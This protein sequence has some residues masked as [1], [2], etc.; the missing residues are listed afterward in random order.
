LNWTPHAYQVEAKKFLLA[1]EGAALFA[2][3]GLGK[4]SITLSAIQELRSRGECSRALVVAPLRVC[5]TVW[6]DEVSK[7][8]DFRDLR[9][10]VVHGGKKHKALREDADIYLINPEGLV[11]LTGQDVAPFDV[12]VVDELTKFKHT[13]TLRFKALRPLLP[14]FRR[15][16]GLTGTPTANGLMDLFGQ[17]FVLDRGE[18]LG[19]YITHYRSRYF[20]QGRDGFSW[21]LRPGAEKAIQTRLAGLATTIRANDHLDMPRLIENR[22]DV[23][24]PAKARKVYKTFERTL[25]ATLEDDT[26]LVGT[27]AASASMKCRQ[28]ASGAVYGADDEGAAD[29]SRV[30]PI[31]DA[32]LEALRGLLDE[33]QGSPAIVMYNFRHELSRLRGMLGE[34]TP[35]I[36]GGSTAKT[37]QE[38]AAA[39]NGGFLPVLLGHPAAMGHGLNLQRGGHHVVWFGLSWDY[40]L[41]DQTIRRLWR[42]GSDSSRVF[43]H[44]IVAR[45]TVDEA[46]MVALQKKKTS[47]NDLMDALRDYAASRKGLVSATKAPESL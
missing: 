42:Q 16:W 43:V 12:L 45:D 14:T 34:D 3:P 9:V 2:E 5:Y 44:H 23:I 20:S 33:L 13:G 22:V 10:S 32:K 18:S 41:Y 38:L 37:S 35:A 40:E 39:W 27:T 11:W 24:L 19:R 15:R 17:C 29:Y 6:P 47:Q 4:T 31:H 21:E 8:D 25:M 46:V 1:R 26:M 28:I 36:C 30:I 7:W